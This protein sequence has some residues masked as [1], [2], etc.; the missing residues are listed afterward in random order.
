MVQPITIQQGRTRISSTHRTRPTASTP[1]AMTRRGF[2]AR[3]DERRRTSGVSRHP[4]QNIEVEVVLYSLPRVY[5]LIPRRRARSF[6]I[7]T[8]PQP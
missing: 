6:L 3:L 8:P 5:F 4:N 7:D 1:A 2:L